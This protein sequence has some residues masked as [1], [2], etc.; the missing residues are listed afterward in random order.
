MCH[1]EEL[2]MRP[3]TWSAGIAAAA[4]AIA[5]AGCEPPATIFRSRADLANT[6][7]IDRLLVLANLDVDGRVSRGFAGGLENRLAACGVVSQVVLGPIAADPLAASHGTGFQPSAALLVRSEGGQLTTNQDIR[8]GTL[9]FGF[10]L[11]DAASHKPSWVAKAEFHLATHNSLEDTL[12]G[13]RLA[14]SIAT[15]LRDD[16]VLPGCPAASVGWQPMHAF[17]GCADERRR[18]LVDAMHHP[19]DPERSHLIASAPTCE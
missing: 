6:A 13:V 2:A 14:T 9:Y 5:L 15:R 12:E 4:A 19:S 16:G 1:A 7:P 11:H 8:Y 10:Q 17:S 18:I 3:T